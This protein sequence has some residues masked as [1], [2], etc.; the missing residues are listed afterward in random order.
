MI[1]RT[2]FQKVGLQQFCQQLSKSCIS[3]LDRLVFAGLGDVGRLR[4]RDSFVTETIQNK[5]GT[6]QVGAIPKAQE[7]QSF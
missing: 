7:A 2:V 5:T 3:H 4:E 6:S 1:Y